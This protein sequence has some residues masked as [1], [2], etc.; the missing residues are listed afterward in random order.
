MAHVSSF[1]PIVGGSPR[2][3]I[4]GTM[5]G[6]ASLHA[7][8]YYAHPRNA[9]WG[10]LADLL[11]F[12]AGLDYAARTRRLVDADI[13]VWDVLRSCK[14]PGSLDS[15]IDPASVIANDFDTFFARHPTI[16]RVCFNGAA[17]ET[18]YRRHVL[19]TLAL[20][21]RRQYVRLPSTS[22]ANAS[23]PVAEKVRLWRAAVLTDA[24]T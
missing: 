3:L 9:F 14:R 4:L 22:P 18:L 12:D 11:G 6:T 7:Q 21:T 13:A 24:P 2:T 8:Q 17:A 10:I 1:P 20:E 16:A 15:R 5:P 23:V 19:H